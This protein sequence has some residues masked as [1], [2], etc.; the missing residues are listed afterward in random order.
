MTEDNYDCHCFVRDD[1]LAGVFIA[2]KI[3]PTVDAYVA[4]ERMLDD[5]MKQYSPA[6]WKDLSDDKV[7]FPLNDYLQAFQQTTTTL[8]MNIV[9]QDDIKKEEFEPLVEGNLDYSTCLQ[10]LRNTVQYRQKVSLNRPTA[11]STSSKLDADN[12][13][14]FDE[15]GACSGCV[16]A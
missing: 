4:V 9:R 12:P 8:T 7:E 6:T 14:M 2:D 10:N 3:Y 16:I 5:F 11:Y 13:L 1:N 15:K